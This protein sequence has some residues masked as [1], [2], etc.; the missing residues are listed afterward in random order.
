MTDYE[1][2][3]G[4]TSGDDV[5]L[6]IAEAAAILKEAVPDANIWRVD[7]Y[8]GDDD[9]QDIGIGL[10]VTSAMNVVTGLNPQFE[11]VEVIG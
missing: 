7:V 6:C 9:Q 1:V 11:S 10:N 4:T 3:I 5:Q 8:G 2:I